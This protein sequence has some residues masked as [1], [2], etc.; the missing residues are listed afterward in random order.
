M[1]LEGATGYSKIAR[2]ARGPARWGFIAIALFIWYITVVLFRAPDMA[3]V[4]DIYKGL[5]GFR[6]WG[7]WPEGATLVVALT[8]VVFA[9]HHLDQAPRIVAAAKRVPA[10]LAIPILISIVLACSLIAAG[11][12]QS[13]YYFDF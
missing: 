5:L 7:P 11:R 3:A 12:P 1:A 2:D 13:F 8:A 4:A 10:A 9:T 6:G